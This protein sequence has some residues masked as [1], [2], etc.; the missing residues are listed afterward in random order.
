MEG[1]LPFAVKH[2]RFNAE[3]EAAIEEARQI[4]AGKTP[5]KRYSSARELFNELDMDNASFHKKEALY[6]IIANTSHTL[7]FL[8]P[9]SP[10]LN[11]IEHY[12]SALKRNL[13]AQ[14]HRYHSVAETFDSLLIVN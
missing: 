6:A 3:T 11:P 9:Y 14:A 4:I 5:A 7:L 1:E 2:P 13:A 8:P 12:W 10:D